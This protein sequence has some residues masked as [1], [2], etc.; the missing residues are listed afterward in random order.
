MSHSMHN[1]LQTEFNMTLPDMGVLQSAAL[2]GYLFG[3][4]MPLSK[5]EHN[6]DLSAWLPVIH[7]D[8]SIN[9]QHVSVSDSQL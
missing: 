8:L 3:Q 5:T 1:D 4:V 2:I 7:E 9:Q 6:N